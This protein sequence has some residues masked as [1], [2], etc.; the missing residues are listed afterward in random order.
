MV[1]ILHR[2][3]M[4]GA[5]P[6]EV[7]AAL[8]TIEGLSGWWTRDTTG[9]PGVGGLIEFR[10]GPGGF[11]MVVLES[12]PGK[13]VRWEVVDGPAEWIGTTVRFDLTQA[14]D[15]AIVMFAHEG[16]A[17]PVDFMYHCS[18]KWA[19]YLVSLKELVETG[20]GSPDP[21]DLKISDWH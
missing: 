16:W 6:D 9:D 1:D 20:T 12:V 7:Y 18:T 8:T 4:K 14:D 19:T 3:G 10:F 11:D 21:D 2:V 5:T 15:F 17:E 13:L